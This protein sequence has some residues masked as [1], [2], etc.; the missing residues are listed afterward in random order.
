MKGKKEK[1]YKVSDL[2]KVVEDMMHD[3]ME[4]L[5]GALRVKEKKTLDQTEMKKINLV[6]KGISYEVLRKMGV[7]K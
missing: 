3:E 2:V 1:K 5:M 7:F 4:D 6:A